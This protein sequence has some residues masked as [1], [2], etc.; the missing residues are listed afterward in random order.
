R[1]HCTRGAGARLYLGYLATAFSRRKRRRALGQVREDSLALAEIAK[2]DASLLAHCAPLLG[3]FCGRVQCLVGV[4]E[5]AY[6]APTCFAIDQIAQR[7]VARRRLDLGQDR[8]LEELRVLVDLAQ[9]HADRANQQPGADLWGLD[10]VEDHL[11]IHVDR[12][13]ATDDVFRIGAYLMHRALAGVEISLRCPL[14]ENTELAR[15][16]ARAGRRTAPAVLLPKQRR[17]SLLQELQTAID[18]PGSSERDHAYEHWP[19]PF[20]TYWRSERR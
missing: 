20:R 5:A 1:H 4:P 18:V 19:S 8:R 15:G 9:R 11:L 17:D 13:V 7:Q 16:A 6:G 3:C 12:Q 2:A 10:H 14:R